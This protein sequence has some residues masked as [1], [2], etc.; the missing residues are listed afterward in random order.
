MG[1]LVEEYYLRLQ[2]INLIFKLLR[3]QCDSFAAVFLAKNDRSGSH[4][5]HIN[6][7]HLAIS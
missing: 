7:K 1:Y 2:D 6:I 4:N 3:I 5:K